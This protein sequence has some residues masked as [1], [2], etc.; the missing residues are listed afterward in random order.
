M[1]GIVVPS[2]T[3]AL[4][5][6]VADFLVSVPSCVPDLLGSPV[7]LMEGAGEF[8]LRHIFVIHDT[9]LKE[10]RRRIESA[11]EHAGIPPT[12][13][14]ITWVT[15]FRPEDVFV[16]ASRI[17]DCLLETAERPHEATVLLKHMLAWWILPRTRRSASRTLRR[18]HFSASSPLLAPA[19]TAPPHASRPSDPT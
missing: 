19:S 12:G 1:I 7:N 8:G 2:A 13:E 9:R 16:N 18:T 11:L 10:R 17:D 14:R 6:Q 15:R 4:H 3:A 5:R